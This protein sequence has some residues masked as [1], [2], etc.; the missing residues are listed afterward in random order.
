MRILFLIVS[1]ACLCSAG[2]TLQGTVLKFVYDN[3]TIIIKSAKYDT[4]KLGCQAISP[5]EYIV[6]GS[7]VNVIVKNGIA[8][9]IT[10]R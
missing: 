8:T 10:L 6:A 5:V 1:L 7:Q 4:L 9:R 2:D 3:N